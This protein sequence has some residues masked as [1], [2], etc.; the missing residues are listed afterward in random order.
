M[1]GV[2]GT[3]ATVTTTIATTVSGRR[4][5]FVTEYVDN[6]YRAYPLTDIYTPVCSSIFGFD[7]FDSEECVPPDFDVIWESEGYYSPGI[8]W[9]GYTAG[10]SLTYR[11]LKPGQTAFNCVPRCVVSCYYFSHRDI[12]VLMK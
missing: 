2:V 8:C 12:A 9:S 3:G 7:D 1:A 10:C 4:E 11:D 5:V 6:D